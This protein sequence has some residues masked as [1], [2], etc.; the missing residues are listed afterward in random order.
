MS[1]GRDGIK[2]DAVGAIRIGSRAHVPVIAHE[3]CAETRIGA[4]RKAPAR[5]LE[6]MPA[7]QDERQR[8][9][10]IVISVQRALH[11]GSL[12]RRQ[13]CCFLLSSG[14]QKGSSGVI[15]RLDLIRGWFLPTPRIPP[16]SGAPQPM[17]WY[18]TLI[19]LHSLTKGNRDA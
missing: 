17:N 9:G 4:A 2:V 7:L 10:P 8:S 15:Q 6:P 18:L 11:L 14:G 5:E 12:R 1:V 3:T 16:R 13:L 19:I